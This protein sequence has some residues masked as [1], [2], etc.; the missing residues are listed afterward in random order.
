MIL[1]IKIFSSDSTI[2]EGLRNALCDCPAVKLIKTANTL[3][4]HPPDTWLDALYLPLFA[5]MEL[6]KAEPLV[7]RSQILMTSLAEQRLGLPPYIVTGTCLA[8][9]DPRGPI[10]ETTLLVTAVFQAIRQF[11]TEKEHPISTVGFWADDLLKMVKSGELRS[12]LKE[13]VPEL[14]VN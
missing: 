10:P 9:D 3:A 14:G 6:W 12:I 7:H 11:N 1:T 8:K 4:L 13:A 5:T 2:L